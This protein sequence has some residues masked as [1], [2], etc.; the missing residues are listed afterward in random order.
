MRALD[1]ENRLSHTYALRYLTLPA[2][3]C[4]FWV[5]VYLFSFSAVCLAQID[6]DDPLL[7]DTCPAIQCTST[8]KLSLEC[9]DLRVEDAYCLCSQGSSTAYE[10]LVSACLFSSTF[11]GTSNICAESDWVSESSS[12]SESCSY[13]TSAFATGHCDDCY[14]M[15]V[16]N[17]S[18]IDNADAR[19]L[20]E[21]NSE[22]FRSLFTSCAE[23]P[24]TLGLACPTAYFSILDAKFQS[25]CSY[26][27]AIPSSIPGC[28]ECQSQV[29]S[30]LGCENH[31]EYT[32]LC[33]DVGY[34]PLLTAC[35]SSKCEVEDQITARLEHS[36]VCAVLSLGDAAAVT[37]PGGEPKS[38]DTDSVSG[39][40]AAPDG[41]TDDEDDGGPD[42]TTIIGVVAG[43][44]AGLVALLIGGYFLFR[45]RSKRMSKKTDKP[46]V[47]PPRP[48]KQQQ[49]ANGIYE[50]W[51][52]QQNPHQYPLNRPPLPHR[53]MRPFE[54]HGQSPGA[55]QNGYVELGPSRL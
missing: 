10:S 47:L 21:E 2:P 25:S 24:T 20:C 49:N 43:A 8:A 16:Q 37:L 22:D 28:T 35:I 23:I 53:P 18:C 55:P 9:D 14:S 51:S 29:A 4:L 36:A 38:Q 11:S 30:E 19:C 46:P 41:G 27:N 52:V 45:K 39:E 6:S 33:S 7:I 12:L 54:V 44:I 13:A 26:W 1:R 31:F 48:P 5:I 15:A 50:L 32:C 17:V 40:T 42:I 34:L 3:N